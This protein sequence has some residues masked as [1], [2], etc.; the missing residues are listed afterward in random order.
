MYFERK[1]TKVVSKPGQPVYVYED[2][3][4]KM[5]V[6][7]YMIYA[8]VMVAFVIITTISYI[9]VMMVIVSAGRYI[10]NIIPCI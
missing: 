1:E 10:P 6:R 5:I 9:N 3:I 2:S 7:V 4:R 8:C